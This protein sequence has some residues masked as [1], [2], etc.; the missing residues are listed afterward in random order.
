MKLALAVTTMPNFPLPNSLLKVFKRLESKGFQ[1]YLVGGCV[2]DYLRGKT[3]TD[4]DLTS[5]ATPEEIITTFAD[6]TVIKTGIRHGTVTIIIDSHL[7]EITTHRI[8]GPYSDSRHPDSV[9]YSRRIEDDLAR[10][11][12]TINA[13]AYHP[14]TGII[15]PYGGKNDLKSGLIRCVGNPTI[16]F[17]EDALRILRG[18][19]FQSVLGFKIEKD[20][21]RAM[22]T[23]SAKLQKISEERIAKEMTGLLCGENVKATLIQGIGIIGEFIPELLLTINFDQKNPYHCHDLL[24]HLAITVA[25]IKAESHLRWTML[26]HDLG[27]PSTFL[28]DSDGVGHFY[29]HAKKSVELANLILN[30]L[31]F[32]KEMLKHI[33]LLIKY[34]DTPIEADEKIVKR[35]LNRLGEKRFRDLLEVKKADCLAQ[36]Q[37]YRYRLDAIKEVEILIDSILKEA[38]CFSLKNL[39]VDGNDL[40]HLGL[41]P[42]PEIGQTL[43]H[44]LEMV[45]DQKIKNTKTSLL[46]H[47][48]KENPKNVN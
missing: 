45:I 43:N 27:K 15:D 38:A 1:V 18:L 14:A 8:E 47:V 22:Q 41:K 21:F 16:R 17:K 10:R 40:I 36:D 37:Q 3:P 11:D 29:G 24:T 20:T 6:Y 31:K 26:L 25:S 13:M 35:W 30:R 23:A 42:G 9:D 32:P 44:L 33:L 28:I 12:F 39:A 46:K 34:H 4:Y 48:K 19:R 2:R 7:V 5:D